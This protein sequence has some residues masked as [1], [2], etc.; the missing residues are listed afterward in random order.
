M[1]VRNELRS[2][3]QADDQQSRARKLDHP[4]G[5]DRRFVNTSAD[6]TIRAWDFD[7]P[8]VINYLADP[9]MHSMPAVTLH[10][11][12]E[13]YPIAIPRSDR[14]DIRPPAQRSILLRRVWTTRSWFTARTTSAKSATSVSPATLSQGTRAKWTSLWRESGSAGETARATWSSGSGRL[15]KSSR[16]S[17]HTGRWSLRMSGSRMKQYVIV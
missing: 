1:S 16:V 12:S 17:G 2:I 9:H 8:V 3:T 5:R 10:P 13:F 6:K 11:S 14:A 7:I 4:H 15:D